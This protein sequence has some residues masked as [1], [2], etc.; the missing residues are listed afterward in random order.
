[1]DD[2]KRKKPKTFGEYMQEWYDTFRRPKVGIAHDKVYQNLMNRIPQEIKAKVINRVTAQ[3][4]QAH[5][6]GIEKVRPKYSIKILLASCLEYAFNEGRIKSNIGKLLV[7][8][9][10]KSAKRQILSRED[11]PK[12]IELLPQ[13]YRNYVIGYLYTGCRL[14]ELMAVTEQDVDRVNKTIHIRGTKTSNA[15]R[16]IPLLPELENISFP[17]QKTTKKSLQMQISKACAK[18]GIK[19]TPHDFRHTFATRC[20]ELGINMKVYSQW[21]GHSS[22]KITGDLYT[23]TT[24]SLI[25]AESD[26]LRN[27]TANSTAVRS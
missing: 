4:L 7:A 6:N 13:R 5:L 26:K 8:E 11:E 14:S 22:I 9:K 20:N 3:E 27:S 23:H 15:D 19:V 18:L 21:L 1:M 10:G 12:L 17:L 16:V 2:K 25:K 24:A